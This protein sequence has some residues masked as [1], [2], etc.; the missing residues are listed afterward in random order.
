MASRAS[1]STWGVG[2][3]GNFKQPNMR[4]SKTCFIL[5][6]CRILTILAKNT[7]IKAKIENKWHS[8]LVQYR[9]PFSLK[10][11]TNLYFTE[12]VANPTAIEAFYLTQIGQVESQAIKTKGIMAFCIGSM[13][14]TPSLCKYRMNLHFT[15]RVANP[16]AIG[17]LYLTQIGKVYLSL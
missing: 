12:W 14:N 17:A 9:T 4:F 13:Q 7:W 1:P 2:G 15:E 16:R 6:H 8:V 5:Q 11:R 10:Y 3:G